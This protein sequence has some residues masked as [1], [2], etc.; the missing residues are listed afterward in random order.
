MKLNSLFGSSEMGKSFK[1][2]IDELQNTCFSQCLLSEG[3][4]FLV[5]RENAGTL[6]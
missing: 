5:R 4:L 3:K 2:K 1:I 6:T